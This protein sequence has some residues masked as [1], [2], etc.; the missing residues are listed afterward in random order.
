VRGH[1]TKS[2]HE[3]VQGLPDLT[4]QR[5]ANVDRDYT[6]RI[7]TREGWLIVV[8]GEVLVDDKDLAAALY[9][10]IGKPI[11][12]FGIEGGVLSFSVGEAN[13]RAVPDPDYESWN[14]VGPLPDK[15][16]IVCL[17][18]GELAIWD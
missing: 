3:A 5:L 16:R 2:Y 17:P 7:Y 15:P 14:L 8:E 12:D 4:G 1:S 11:T 9:G 6:L 13:I 18:G 10:G